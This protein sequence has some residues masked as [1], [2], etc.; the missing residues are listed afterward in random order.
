M[1]ICRNGNSLC[2]KSTK[3]KVRGW[4]KMMARIKSESPT[5]EEKEETRVKLPALEEWIKMGKESDTEN[6]R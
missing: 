5:R 3:T 6:V 1:I 4:R 2:E